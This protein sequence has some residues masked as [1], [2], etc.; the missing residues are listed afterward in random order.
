MPGKSKILII[1]DDKYIAAFV[2]ASLES[3]GYQVLCGRDAAEGMFLFSSH[4]PVVVLLDLGLPDR[5]GTE[6]IGEIRGYAETPI[7]VVSARGQETEK[8]SALDAGAY[9][10]VT[11]PFNM[12]ELL[13]R[14]RV[15]ERLSA[16]LSAAAPVQERYERDWLSVDFEKRLVC[17]DGQELH[18]TPYEYKLLCV[19]IRNRD[20]VLTY[21][22]IIRA[23]YGYESGGAEGVRVFVSNLRRKI[24]KDLTEPR[25]I[26]TEMGIGY[27]WRDE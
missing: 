12:A 23:L 9:D 2:S 15:A 16:K 10:Y 1:E 22:F 17:A 11:K 3:A 25:F 14:I 26:L 19:M 4:R 7:I 8:I 20:K 27:R 18:L 21:N 24:E 5:D 6:L 13:A